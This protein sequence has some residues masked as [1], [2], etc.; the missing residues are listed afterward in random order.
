VFQARRSHPRSLSNKV[1]AITGGA[2]GI[3][4]ATA[5]VLAHEGARVAVGDLDG[6]LAEGVAADLGVNAVGVGVDVSDNAAF[7]AF[8]DRVERQLGPLDVLVNNAGI[9]MPGPIE[10]E[11]EEITAREI[12]INL[13][14]VIHGTRQA[15]QRMKPRRSGHIVNISSVGGRIAGA[16]L[17]TYCATKFG[18]AGFSEAVALELNGTGVDIS[19][20]FPPPCKTDLSAGIDPLRAMPFVQP[21]DVAARIVET[22]KWPRFAVPV[23]KTMGPM[24]WLNQVLPFRVRAALA[25]I[26]KA[27]RM[28]IDHGQ[29]AVYTQRLAA[30]LA[31]SSVATI[32]GDPAPKHPAK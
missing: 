14:A 27:D 2:R 12:A 32:A 3:G 30:A 19:V 9:L 21:E 17:A 16:R 10:A 6:D 5:R 31:P 26:M 22:L 4:Y 7:A 1:V 25:H 24:L 8:L 28:N 13:H 18:V 29:R 20:V 23:P 11:D 15:V